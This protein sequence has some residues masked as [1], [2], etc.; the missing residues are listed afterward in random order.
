M[1]PA[2]LSGIACPSRARVPVGAIVLIAEIFLQAARRAL[3]PG[4]KV[5]I[6]AK[7]Y[8][9][10]MTRMPELFDDIQLHPH[11]QYMVVEGIQK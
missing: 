1:R 5:L 11:K 7:S 6:V 3:K 9:W 4:G 2:K 8:A 10:F